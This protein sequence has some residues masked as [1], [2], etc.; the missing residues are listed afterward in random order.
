MKI[1]ANSSLPLTASKANLLRLNTI[2]A[3]LLLIILAGLGYA[4]LETELSRSELSSHFIAVGLY[5]LAWLLTQLRL[6]KAWPVSDYEYFFQ[7]LIDILLIS[8]LLYFSGGASNPF[9]SYYLVPLSIA[10]AI[11]PWRLTWLIAAISLTSYS[12][13]LFYYQPFPSAAPPAHHHSQEFNQHVLGMWLN[14]AISSLLITYFVVKMANT[15][16][17]KETQ[18]MAQ[19][20]ETL[21]D[22][23]ILAVAT[24]AAGTAHE[25]GTPLSTMLLLVDELEQAY[26]QDELL[27]EDLLL[28]Q[29]QLNY[30]RETLANLVN[31]AETHSKKQREAKEPNAFMQRLLAHWQV[32][33]PQANVQFSNNRAA[34]D[35]RLLTDSTLEQA[36]LNVLNNAADANPKD[37]QISLGGDE[38]HLTIHIHDQGPGIE[39]AVAE[40]IGKPFIS[41]KGE[42]LGLGLGLGLFLTHATIQRYNGRIEIYNHPQGGAVAEITLPLQLG[43]H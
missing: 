16:R 23:Q 39:L 34:S 36:I 10:A 26:Q 17:E 3:I 32:L 7:L 24:L 31:T 2:R 21:R 40:R 19:R 14:F 29:Q 12:F 20:E 25:L 28:L 38:T 22:E 1:I 42:E 4:L 15:L 37:I 30:C 5:S 9:I 35:S 27:H 13:M 41:N 33:R 6:S 43:N 18:L 8:L 11:L